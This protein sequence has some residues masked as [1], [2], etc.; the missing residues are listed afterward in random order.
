M[1]EDI[2]KQRREW[3]IIHER[4]KA[5]IRTLQ[6]LKKFINDPAF[7][8]KSHKSLLKL[9]IYT[10]GVRAQ[11]AADIIGVKR[12]KIDSWA[13][14]L[15]GRHI[16]IIDSPSH[17]NPVI[18]PTRGLLI[19]YRERMKKTRLSQ[20]TAERPITSAQE[21][22]QAPS[23]PLESFDLEE[24]ISQAQEIATPTRPKILPGLSYLV[25]EEDIED[26]MKM[27]LK[28]VRE[29]VKALYISRLNPSKV[30]AKY[31]LHD[32][33]VVWLTS[34]DPGAG[35]ERV[36]GVQE[37]SLLVTKFLNENPKSI[38][39]I[40]GLEYLMVNSNFQTVLRFVQQIR[41]RISTSDA[42]LLLPFNPSSVDQKQL[43]LLERELEVI[44]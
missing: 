30:K 21:K 16:L 42:T 27:L 18:K 36:S 19:K 8:R 37:I 29:G 4:E 22:P 26:S 44:E 38:I 43:S 20:E 5:R 10:R 24:V 40:D 32:S 17:P 14:A 1:M 6:Q 11:E 28:N 12:E 25:L 39:L 3:K 2:D 34:V 15:A 35:V 41:D 9:A 33:R 13:S 23:P 31:Y 7:D